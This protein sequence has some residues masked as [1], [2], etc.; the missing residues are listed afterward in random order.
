LVFF[1]FGI[2]NTL[3]KIKFKAKITKF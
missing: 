1:K 2:K 3:T